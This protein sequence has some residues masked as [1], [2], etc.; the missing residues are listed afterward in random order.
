MAVANLEL[1]FPPFGAFGG[2]RLYGPVPIE[3]LGFADAGVAWSKG[4]SVKLDL[5][6][7]DGSLTTRRPVRSVG[8]GARLNV[9]GY[10]VLEVD[11]A[12]PLDRPLKNW[13]W[14]FNL[15]PGF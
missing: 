6:G 3:L 8:V 11:Y 1:R 14:L 13:V 4:D 12:K 9:F 10:A 2:R 15:S 5:S 7:A